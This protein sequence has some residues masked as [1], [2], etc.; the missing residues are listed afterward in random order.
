MMGNALLQQARQAAKQLIPYLP[1]P[2][3]YPLAKR[4]GIALPAHPLFAPPAHPAIKA[5]PAAI[6]DALAPIRPRQLPPSWAEAFRLWRGFGALALALRLALEKWAADKS[7]GT[8]L[9]VRDLDGGCAGVLLLKEGAQSAL[10]QRLF[11]QAA[12]DCAGAFVAA[13]APD[14]R[15]P[16]LERILQTLCCQPERLFWLGQDHPG[17]RQACYRLASAGEGLYAGL[18]A[19]QTANRDWFERLIESAPSQPA[20]SCTALVLLPKS[21]AAWQ[22]TWL[23]NVGTQA[24][25]AYETARW[26][27]HT[28]PGGRWLRLRDRLRATPITD[29]GRWW[30]HWFR[31]LATALEDR[32]YAKVEPLWCAELAVE[33][34]WPTLP[35]PVRHRLWRRLWANHND[36]EA[37][38][39]LRWCQSRHKA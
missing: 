35:A 34:G 10:G 6:F 22:E 12:G 27:M 32:D 14:L 37:Q 18:A 2:S 23:A 4:A 8:A 17:C 26:A 16:E 21:P 39:L 19:V 25:W 36:L 29:N 5:F 33:R 24:Q 31:D 3:L 30:F 1:R 13:Y 9:N 28:W 38:L 7:K 11:Q 15:R 20:A